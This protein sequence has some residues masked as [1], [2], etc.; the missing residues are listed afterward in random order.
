MSSSLLRAM[1]T[2]LA[3]LGACQWLVAGAISQATMSGTSISRCPKP[4]PFSLCILSQNF[5]IQ[6][7]L[8]PVVHSFEFSSNHVRSNTPTSS[9]FRSPYNFR[10]PVIRTQ[11]PKTNQNAYLRRHRR[12]PC[13]R[14]LGQDLL[15]HRHRRCDHHL[16]RPDRHK[17]PI[18]AN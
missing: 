16:V 14:C 13:C 8:T 1:S 15:C 17:L 10:F 5:S 11:Q 3:R 9:L 4:R 12:R 7:A 18:Q 2:T 6:K